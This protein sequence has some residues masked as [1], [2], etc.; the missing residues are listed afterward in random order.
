VS[1]DLPLNHR[2]LIESI[3]MKSASENSVA[4]HTRGTTLTLLSQEEPPSIQ[5][6]LFYSFYINS[7]L[8]SRSFISIF[9]LTVQ[10]RDS[11]YYLSPL[12]VARFLFQRDK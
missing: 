2:R 12:S 9:H 3:E 10:F 11:F 8:F 6:Q 7:H 4:M 5:T 1:I